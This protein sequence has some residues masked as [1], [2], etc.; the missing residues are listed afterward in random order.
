MI[1]NTVRILAVT[2][3]LA[4]T[5]FAQ[6]QRQATIVGGGG[7]DRGKCTMEVVV[8][9]VAQVEIRGTTATLRTL[10][11]QPA[12]WRRFE[13]TGAMPANPANFRFSG[14]DG[15]GR[16]ELTRDPRNGGVA[17][18]Q[19]EDKEGG[20]EGYTFDINWDAHVPTAGGNPN[21]GPV[22]AG[23]QPNY[24]DRDRSNSVR[25]PGNHPTY[26]GNPSNYQDREQRGPG[27]PPAYGDPDRN[28]YRSEE[29]YRPNY[30]DSDYYRRYGH[31][32]AVDEAVRVCQQAVFTQAARRFRTNDIHFHRTAIDDNPGREDWVTGSLDIHRG[33]R[34]E[35]FGFSCSVNFDNGRVRSA[36][37]DPR[38]LPDDP[39]W[40]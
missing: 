7:P 33:P 18:V 16:Q 24:Q 10:S 5:V 15:R 8:D 12:Q 1:K 21:T 9:D 30:R 14:V 19:I 40:H 6:N 31:P 27:N 38:P 28:R 32:F 39:R 17:V 34:E 37:L 13:C 11:G 36:E 25:A 4:A 29:Q 20:A 26:G 35:R 22:T 23:G 2:A 3:A